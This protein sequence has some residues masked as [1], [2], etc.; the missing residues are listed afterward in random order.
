MGAVS[1]KCSKKFSRYLKDKICEIKQYL[2]YILIIINE[3]ILVT[4]RKFSNL[5][6]ICMRNSAT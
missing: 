6:K 5:Q 1:E 3:N 2:N 4:V